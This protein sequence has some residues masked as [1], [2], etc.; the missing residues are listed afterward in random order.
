MDI[1]ESYLELELP[2]SAA[3][4]AARGTQG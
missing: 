1:V 2:D 3:A 4:Q